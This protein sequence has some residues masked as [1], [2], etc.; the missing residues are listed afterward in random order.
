MRM[1]VN[2][3]LHVNNQTNIPSQTAPGNQYPDS[4]S[5]SFVNTTKY[6]SHPPPSLPM[7]ECNY[8]GMNGPSPGYAVAQSKY[9]LCNFFLK[10]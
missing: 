3:Q 5:P 4:Q 10:E 2:K 6:L 8:N 9:M 1:D 7:Y